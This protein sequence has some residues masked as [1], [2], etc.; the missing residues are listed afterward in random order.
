MG[1]ISEPLNCF[2]L[3]ICMKMAQAEFQRTSCV[4]KYRMVFRRSPGGARVS[5]QFATCRVAIRVTTELNISQHRQTVKDS[6]RKI[7]HLRFVI[8]LSCGVLPTRRMSS[9]RARTNHP[10]RNTLFQQPGAG[11]NSRLHRQQVVHIF[12]WHE[13]Y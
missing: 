7:F 4:E 11:T 10:N 5:N 3:F 2:C 9:S 1:E 12:L 6:R 13:F 8:S